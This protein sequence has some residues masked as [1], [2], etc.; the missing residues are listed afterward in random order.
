MRTNLA[1]YA[2]HGL[3][4][5][6]LLAMAGDKSQRKNLLACLKLR[7]QSLEVGHPHLASFDV[8]LQ[9]GRIRVEEMPHFR[10]GCDVT[11]DQLLQR[12]IRSC[13]PL[14]LP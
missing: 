9:V 5:T 7:L 2:I 6:F 10:L 1:P 3:A 8:P 13:L 12:A 4:V 14:V 11:V